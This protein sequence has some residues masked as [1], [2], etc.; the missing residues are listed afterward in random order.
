MNRHRRL[1]A[2]FILLALGGCAAT[3]AGQTRYMPYSHD[4]HSDLRGGGGEGGGGGNGM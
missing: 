4:D 1:A 3:G 2:L